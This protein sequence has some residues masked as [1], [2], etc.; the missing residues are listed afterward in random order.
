MLSAVHFI[1]Y[2]MHQVEA[3][4]CVLA[5]TWRWVDGS[6]LTYTL[7]GPGQPSGGEGYLYLW[8]LPPGLDNGWNDAWE[9]AST[10]WGGL[11]VCMRRGGAT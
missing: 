6:P 3:P 9:G 7:W 8:A 5:G 2:R 10:N 11:C 4:C 1:P